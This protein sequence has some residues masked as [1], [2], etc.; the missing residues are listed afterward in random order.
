[1][2]YLL[3]ANIS[4]SLG[5]GFSTRTLESHLTTMLSHPLAEVRLIAKSMREEAKQLSPGLLKHVGISDY[6]ITRRTKVEIF[7]DHYRQQKERETLPFFQAITDEKRV[8][9]IFEGD[10]DNRICASLLFEA[11]RSTGPSFAECMA[12]VEQMSGVEKDA[13]MASALAD[14]GPHD[15]MPRALQHSSIMFEYLIDF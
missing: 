5:A 2:R 8:H 15:R 1:M 6:E 10:L 12:Q 13:L 9:L 7:A 4:T 11:S 14:R 3:P